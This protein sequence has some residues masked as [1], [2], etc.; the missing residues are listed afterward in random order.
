[1]RTGEGRPGDTGEGEQRQDA[2]REDAMQTRWGKVSFSG[3]EE[4]NNGERLASV[5]CYTAGPA[6]EERKTEQDMEIVGK[7]DVGV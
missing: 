5:Y 4:E 1:M 7:K 3:V 6:E 2:L